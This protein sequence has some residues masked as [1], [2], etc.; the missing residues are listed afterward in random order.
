MTWVSGRGT[1]LG[2][3]VHKGRVGPTT[4]RMAPTRMGTSAWASSGELGAAQ[5]DGVAAAS[6]AATVKAPSTSPRRAAP[7]RPRRKPT[8]ELAGRLVGAVAVEAEGAVEP[9]PQLADPA[10][11]E[12]AQA[13][14]VRARRQRRRRR[15][16]HRHRL[17][18]DDDLRLGRRR[19]PAAAARSVGVSS[20][21][22]GGG[23]GSGL[24]GR[25]RCSRGSTA[26]SGSAARATMSAVTSSAAAQSS[27]GHDVARAADDGAAGVAR[28]DLH[29]ERAGA[30]GRRAPPGGSCRAAARRR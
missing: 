23:A 5:L 28:G 6:T 21:A 16:R 11:L 1:P 15:R 29:G 18:D 12:A 8:R 17:L 7:K 19:R 9:G 14:E 22:G 4:K 10:T 26:V 30:L 24:G 3:A 2:R 20:V 13:Q 25:G 27:V